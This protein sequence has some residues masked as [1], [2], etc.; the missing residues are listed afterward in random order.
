MALLKGNLLTGVIIGAAA[1]LAA[2]EG[3]GA[4]GAVRPLFRSTAKMG[5]MGFERMKEMFSRVGESM[6]DIVAEVQ[7]DL[8]SHPEG[9]GA[10]DGRRGE[11]KISRR[12]EAA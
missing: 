12:A 6:E 9:K 4:A 5:V 11:R 8:K 1:G 3:L 7:A 10:G 2:R